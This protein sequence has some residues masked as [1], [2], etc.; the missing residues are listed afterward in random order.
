MAAQRHSIGAQPQGRRLAHHGTVSHVTERRGNFR[1]WLRSEVPD[2]PI[3]V[4][5][6]PNKRHFGQGWEGLKVTQGA[7]F[8]AR[9]FDP[10]FTGTDVLTLPNFHIYL[11]LFIDGEPS[12]PFSATTLPVGND[13]V[14]PKGAD[15]R[16]GTSAA[17]SGSSNDSRQSASVPSAP[18][19]PKDSARGRNRPSPRYDFSSAIEPRRA[20]AEDERSP[21]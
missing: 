3:E 6:S 11:K 10:K 12:K 1:V 2:V 4:C 20:G 19:R 17:Q 16:H 21:P 5:S 8:I 7:A 18:V 9:E 15:V 13:T 14:C